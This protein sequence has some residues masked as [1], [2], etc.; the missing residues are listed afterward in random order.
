MNEYQGLKDS[1]GRI[2]ISMGLG[3]RVPMFDAQFT[4]F[5]RELGINSCTRDCRTDIGLLWF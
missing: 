5:T 1:G 4:V 3:M 2:G